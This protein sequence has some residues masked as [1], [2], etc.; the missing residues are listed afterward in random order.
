MCNSE[1]AAG[2]FELFVKQP[3]DE[4]VISG[5]GVISPW[6]N[7]ADEIFK[8]VTDEGISSGANGNFCA[9]RVEEFD[10]SKKLGKNGLRE[11]NRATRFGLCA[12]L[13]CLSEARLEPSEIGEHMG[14]V[15]GSHLG[16][17]DHVEEMIQTIMEE[18]SYGLSP[19]KAGNGG[20][21]V[22]AAMMGI[23]FGAKALNTTI[24]NSFTSGMDAIQHG[25]RSLS[26]N[27]AE[28]ILA[29]GAE[30][31]S[32]YWLEW[33]KGNGSILAY[34]GAGVLLLEKS[35]TALARGVRSMAVVK[36]Y[37]TAP[38]S[39]INSINKTLAATLKSANLEMDAVDTFVGVGDFGAEP[40]EAKSLTELG[41]TG[42]SLFSRPTLG[43]GLGVAGIFQIMI[44][45]KLLQKGHRNVLIHLF[46]K[47]GSTSAM[48][49]SLSNHEQGTASERM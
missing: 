10:A 31:A 11:L 37:S 33:H 34:E 17:M 44:A 28:Y 39:G 9:R 24:H 18:G 45:I 25:C 48:L 35:H 1:F 36:G 43:E 41:F 6:G 42:S 13:D 12:A 49:L 47:N 3:E 30:A 19:L 8:T 4:I 32:R 23:R 14:V 38:Y 15:I 20:I 2:G 22:I 40:I 16:H 27:H 5:C 29:G 21:N 7:T 46:G 26:R